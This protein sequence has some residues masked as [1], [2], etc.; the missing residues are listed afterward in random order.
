MTGGGFGGCTVN[1]VRRD[2][3][4]EFIQSLK[5]AYK[6]QFG[7]EGEAYHCEAVDGA[8]KRNGFVSP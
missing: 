7:I 3:A 8:M 5:V 4:D 2:A 1:L 6:E